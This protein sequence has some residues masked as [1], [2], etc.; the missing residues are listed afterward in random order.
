MSLTKHK[1]TTK[2]TLPEYAI[3]QVHEIYLNDLAL[4]AV[5]EDVH[6]L[7][8]INYDQTGTH[9]LPVSKW[10]MDI[11]GSKRVEVTGLN[12]KRQMTIDLAGTANGEVLASL[13]IYSSSTSKS[14]PK[15]VTFPSDWYIT[16]TPAHWSNESTMLEYI[17]KV[18]HP[19]VEKKREEI[20]LDSDFP[21]LVLFDHFSGQATQAV[22]DH[23][24]KYHIMYVLIPKTCTDW[25]QPVHLAVYKPFNDCLKQPFQTWYAYQNQQQLQQK[26]D[27]TSVTPIDMPLTIIKQLHAQ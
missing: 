27:S 11:K 22:F 6:L 14:L 2:S 26:P 8:I 1:A 15:N 19:Y 23:L 7:L 3:D 20:H 16:T 17:D 25:L 10:T 4:I 5:M 18:I 21:A 13:L 9:F 12:N 24:E